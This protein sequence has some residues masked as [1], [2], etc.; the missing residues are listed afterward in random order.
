MALQIFSGIGIGFLRTLLSSCSLVLLLALAL[1]YLTKFQKLESQNAKQ[2]PLPPGPKPWPLVGCLPTMLA[3]KP[4]F[5]WI[6]KLMKEMNTEIACIRLGNVHVI[7]VTSPEI[8][9]EFL[10]VQDAVFAS[11]PL[12]MSTDLTT[13]GYLTTTLVPLGEQWKKMKRVLVTQVLSA[14]KYKWFYGKR[15]EEA[16]HLVRYVYNQ[17][18]TA[19]EGGSVDVRITGRHYC[20]N[21]IR[22]MVFNKRFFGEGMKDGGPGVEEK[23]HVDAILTALA[24]TYAFCLSDYMPCLRGLDL[25]GHEKVM[26]DA[27]GIIKKYQDPIIEARVEQWRDG[28]KKEVDDLLD[29]FIN[30]EDA[31]GNSLLSMEEIKAQITDIMLAAVDNPSNAIEWALAE[32]INKP[33]LLENAVEELDRVVGRERLVQESDFPQLNYIKAC[34]KEAFR[35]HPLGF[36]NLPHVSLADTTVANYFIPKSSHVLLSRVGLGRNPRIWDEPHMFKPERHFKKNGCQVMLTQPDLNLLSFSTGRRG[37]PGIMLGTAMTVMLFARLLQGF[38]W[39]VPP[40][41][42]SIDLSESKNSLEL[43]KPLVALAKPRLPANLYPA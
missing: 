17:C 37:C 8:S 21:V 41:E 43:A 18:K 31:N 3:N 1:I 13:S 20:G 29:V 15:L 30:L 40:N 10:K 11:R 16:D 6:H 22:K 42:T 23:E 24:H 26:K 5:R 19:E 12:T 36:F 14:E 27:I 4:T 39:S 2:L 32:M 9:R 25:D 7:P 35:L 34:A 28:T 38:S 33:K